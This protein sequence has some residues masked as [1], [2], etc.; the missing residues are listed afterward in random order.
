MHFSGE[1]FPFFNISSGNK[2]KG[3]LHPGIWVKGS[4]PIP[5]E[6]AY[7]LVNSRMRSIQ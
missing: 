6:G 3:V 5:V 2:G 1:F 7:S 4:Y